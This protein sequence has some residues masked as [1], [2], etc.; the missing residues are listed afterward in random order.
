M[1]FNELNFIGLT[2]IYNSSFE[3]AFRR[4]SVQTTGFLFYRHIVNHGILVGCFDLEDGRLNP[5][6][7]AADCHF[8][9]C[10]PAV[11]AARWTEAAQMFFRS[12]PE[13]HVSIRTPS[14]AAP[15]ITP[16]LQ[17]QTAP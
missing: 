12:L 2:L 13:A 3:A 11:T 16:P 15:F 17:P 1:K 8:G 7:A 4:R 9:L 5:V 6:I 10:P 14:N